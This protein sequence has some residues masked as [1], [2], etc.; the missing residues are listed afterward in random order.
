MRKLALKHTKVL[1]ILLSAFVLIGSMN[2]NHVKNVVKVD[3][4]IY[5]GSDACGNILKVFKKQYIVVPMEIDVVKNEF[6]KQPIK[7][8]SK[9]FV[10]TAYTIGFESTQKSR[11]QKGYGITSSGY[12]LRGKSRISAKTIAV[13]K[14]IIPIGSKVKLKFINEK[15]SK[16]NSIYVAR[17][18][19]GGVKNYRIDLFIGDDS[20]SLQRAINFGVTECKVTI[21]EN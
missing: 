13:D 17:D 10:V 19:G 5:L 3:R 7:I 18:I 20:G 15:Y 2:A 1:S 9:T 6:T 21:L 8:K 4:N 12:D 11:G 16:Y 14:N